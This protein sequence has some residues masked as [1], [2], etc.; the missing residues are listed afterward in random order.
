M[1]TNASWSLWTI[2]AHENFPYKMH[3]QLAKHFTQFICIKISDSDWETVKFRKQRLVMFPTLL[4]PNLD[5]FFGTDSRVR[6]TTE[7]LKH[8]TK[9]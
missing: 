2:Y 1:F 8:E 5:L 9:I 6:K 7:S 4:H 3:V